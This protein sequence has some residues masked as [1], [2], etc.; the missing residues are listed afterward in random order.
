MPAVNF[1][2]LWP[3]GDKQEYYSP[4]TVIHQYLKL[5]RKYSIVEFKEKVFS[6][7]DRASDRVQEKYGYS[8]SAAAAEAGKIQQKIAQLQ[9]EGI[10]GEVVV[11][12]F[13]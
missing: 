1:S 7:L 2:I 6:A 8:C 9:A 4:S 11:S 10:K 3:D 12:E 13:A 5:D